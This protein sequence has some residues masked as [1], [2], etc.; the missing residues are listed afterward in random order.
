MLSSVVS[1]WIHRRCTVACSER[2]LEMADLD[3]SLP[4]SS[5]FPSLAST[6]SRRKKTRRSLAAIR[7]HSP[8]LTSLQPQSRP[9]QVER[10]VSDDPFSQPEAEGEAWIAPATKVNRAV[11][12]D[13]VLRRQDSIKR[14][15][16]SS[17]AHQR[18]N[19]L[20]LR[21]RS[22][23][24]LDDLAVQPDSISSNHTHIRHAISCDRARDPL[25]LCFDCIVRKT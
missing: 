12:T 21:S 22:T 11:F 8:E 15:V 24:D 6:L 17:G 4:Y 20:F 13:L 10:S 23:R 14:D 5:Y 2:T 7:R 19:S 25:L 3:R 16:T 1:A 18:R 9:A